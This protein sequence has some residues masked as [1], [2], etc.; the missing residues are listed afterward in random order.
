M[1]KIF[2]FVLLQG[3]VFN[4]F[5]ESKI[6]FRWIELGPQNLWIARVVTQD[7]NC[8]VIKTNQQKI[9]MQIQS[10]P[11]Q[12]F[13]VTV[14][15]AILPSSIT[16]ASVEK[17]SFHL[18]KQNPQKIMII[19]D[20]GCR[21]K[22]NVNPEDCDNLNHWPF[23]FIAKH[24]AAFK[25]DLVIHVG[26]YY[27]R[28]APCPPSDKGCK[29]S[30]YGDNWT[31]WRADFFQAAK[32]LLEKAPWVFVRG[33]HEICE[34]GGEG[35][36]KLLDP[37][38]FKHC[39]NHSPIYSVD[40]G[41]TRLFIMD[42]ANA[43]DVV[44]PSDQVGWYENYLRDILKSPAKHNWLITH[45]PFWFIV[46]D[47]DLPQTYQTHFENTLQS[48]WTNISPKNVELLISGHIHTFQTINF[49][50]DRPPQVIVG[51]SGTSLDKNIKRTELKDLSV[52]G[53]PI[54]EGISYIQ[55]GYMTLERNKDSWKAQIRSPK[56]KILEN[57]LFKDRVF[58]CREINKS[59][60]SSQ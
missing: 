51:A 20:T 55:F 34:R 39:L 26:D 53:L 3:L 49:K 21:L 57:C 22:K 16:F 10:S 17:K 28:E 50:K 19:G 9:P 25:P 15:Q 6:L 14:C 46:S 30:P 31:T 2:L 7:K 52:A 23:P 4:V 11:N 59:I 24:G 37:F 43:N 29:G 54:S 40:I 33:N 47:E 56:G 1:K 32:P 18:P 5:A 27:Y 12:K 13:P 45:K 35:W 44:A 60:P 41:D 38:S 8:P 48:A 42:S 58:S 36:S